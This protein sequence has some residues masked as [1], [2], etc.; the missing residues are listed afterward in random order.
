ML[1][2]RSV[3]DRHSS[4]E[5]EDPPSTK[6]TWEEAQRAYACVAALPRPTYGGAFPLL[7]VPSRRKPIENENRIGHTKPFSR[8]ALFLPAAAAAVA[9]E[10]AAAAIA[11]A[12]PLPPLPPA[13][14]PALASPT[15]VSAGPEIARY[16]EL[17]M[18][19][20]QQERA[21]ARAD[22]ENKLVA[23][24]IVE[25]EEKGKVSRAAS[26]LKET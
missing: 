3:W 17:Y 24:L 18:N 2:N 21:I 8:L 9:A 4:A 23:L 26:V 10:V 22:L 13:P 14:A 5:E 6:S 1:P 16:M 12:G 19:M 7:D 20:P 15:A 11:A 25:K